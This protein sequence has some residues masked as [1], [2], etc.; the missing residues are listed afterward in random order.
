MEVPSYGTIYI[1][2]IENDKASSIFRRYM[3]P[4]TVPEIKP[5]PL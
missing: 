5:L 1:S 2:P 3:N 4:E